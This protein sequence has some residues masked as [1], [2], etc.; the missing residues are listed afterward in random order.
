MNTVYV[1]PDRDIECGRNPA[2]W[3]AACPQK[4]DDLSFGGL[5]IKIDPTLKENETKVQVLKGRD[6]NSAYDFHVDPGALRD[7]AV[8]HSLTYDEARARMERRLLNQVIVGHSGSSADALAQAKRLA[9]FEK[10]RQL[11]NGNDL[12]DQLAKIRA[13][14][15]DCP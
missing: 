5:A 6:P 10:I 7:P 11:V 4:K 8:L 1:C 14:V 9:A 3:C 15:E 12:D 13:L 2:S